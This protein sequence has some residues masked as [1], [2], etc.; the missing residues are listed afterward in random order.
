MEWTVLKNSKCSFPNIGFDSLLEVAFYG[1]FGVAWTPTHSYFFS[2]RGSEVLVLV[3]DTRIVAVVWLCFRLVASDEGD[4]MLTLADGD[5]VSR[6][7]F[8]V[9][10]PSHFW[11]VSFSLKTPSCIGLLFS[12]DLWASF[13]LVFGLGLAVMVE[14]L[15]L[16]LSI[17]ESRWW[18][19]L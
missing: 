1:N 10:T 3:F 15:F 11:S 9:C 6:F 4:S 12:F 13:S 2:S 7:L 17:V 5:F 16:S 19:E 8:S 14:L 18:R